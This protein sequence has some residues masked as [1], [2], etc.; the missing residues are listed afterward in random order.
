MHPDATWTAA[1]QAAVQA[2]DLILRMR[3]DGHLSDGT[4]LVRQHEADM[5]AHDLLVTALERAYPGVPVVSEEDVEHCEQRPSCYWLIDPIDGTASW[6]SGYAGFV[7]Q[8]AL[9]EASAVA[10]SAIHAPVLRRTWT[11]VPGHGAF[12]NGVRLPPLRP[13]ASDSDSDSHLVVVD[14]YAQ[15]RGISAEVMAWLGTAHYLESGSIGLKAALVA[16]GEADVFVKDVVVRDW[17]VAPALALVQEVG[18]DV[19]RGD[20]DP[21]VLSGPYDKPQGVLVTS[22]HALGDRV[23]S[24]LAGRHRD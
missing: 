23:G 10:F 2:G 4:R 20:G 21:Y 8:L 15:P 6:S 16:T 12:L 5:A 17:D 1:W 9:I 13:R 18:G 22:G 11:C 24:W 19:R 3:P 7:C 14:N